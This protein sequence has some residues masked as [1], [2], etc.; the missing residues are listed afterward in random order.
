MSPMRVPVDPGTGR[1]TMRHS[2]HEDDHKC[3][4]QAIFS[5][6]ESGHTHVAQESAA[7]NNDRQEAHVRTALDVKGHRMFGKA[8]LLECAPASRIPR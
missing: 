7:K 8:V 3:S 2:M 4:K 1:R 6:D 5:D